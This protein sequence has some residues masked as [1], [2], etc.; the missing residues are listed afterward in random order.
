MEAVKVCL[1]TNA[2][3]RLMRGHEP[4][5]ILLESVDEIM[6]PATVL[7]ELYAGFELGS[8]REA[9]CKQLAL[10][11]SQPGVERLFVDNGVAERYGA[12]IKHLIKSGTPISTN[13]IWI[14]AAAMECG[15]R[16]V[17]YDAHFALIPGLLVLT[18]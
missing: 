3:S 8:R 2:Y 10:F 17:S 12:I 16:L 7:G 4:L 5:K 18:P 11:M 14:A 15:A 6:V 13:D 9:N 1:D